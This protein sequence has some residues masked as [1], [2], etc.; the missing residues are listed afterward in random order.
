MF[1][2][3]ACKFIKA[4]P[5]LYSRIG[6]MPRRFESRTKNNL[7]QVTSKLAIHKNGP[8][9]TSIRIFNKLPNNIKN[10]P[11]QTKFIKILKQFP[12]EKTYYTVEEYLQDN[13][14]LV[15]EF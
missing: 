7:I 5:D 3:E 4:H 6:D 2:L 9:P 14:N 10:E 15:T 13:N 8:Y 11:N 1:I 12:V